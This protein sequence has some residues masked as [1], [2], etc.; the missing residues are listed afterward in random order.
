VFCNGVERCSLGDPLADAHGCVATQACLA[1][2]TCNE[3]AQTCDTA[4]DQ[5][6]D[7]DGD[8]FVAVSCGGDDCDDA[9]PS[10]NPS[11]VELCDGL[12]NDC[13]GAPDDGFATFS[14][15]SNNTLASCTLGQCVITVCSTDYAD[16]DQL[17]GNGCETSLNTVPGDCAGTDCSDKAVALPTDIPVDDGNECTVESCKAGVPS[18]QN[19]VD[20]TSCGNNGGDSGGGTCQQGKCQ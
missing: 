20:G 19:A 17:V 8:G 9:A 10:A 7:A 14:C 6:G 5:G 3:G 1:G 16:C 2:Q 11:G 15:L 12:D 18:V 4:C 13:N